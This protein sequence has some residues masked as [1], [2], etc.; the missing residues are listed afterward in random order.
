MP[1][2]HHGKQRQR[3]LDQWPTFPEPPTGTHDGSLLLLGVAYLTTAAIYIASIASAPSLRQPITWSSLTLLFGL[4]AL[5]IYVYSRFFEFFWARLAAVLCQIVIVFV[6]VLI[7]DGLGYL[8][9]LYFITVSMTY[10]S[11]GFLQA[12]GVALLCLAA[13]FVS[14]VIVA[15]VGGALAMLLR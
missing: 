7:G 5:C 10:L 12:S 9:I 1:H 14:F 8:P 6:I 11:V 4:F 3:P 2:K 15:N 13:L